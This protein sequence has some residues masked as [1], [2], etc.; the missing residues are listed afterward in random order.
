MGGVTMAKKRNLVSSPA[1]ARLEPGPARLQAGT[2]SPGPSM[3]AAVP[4][5][6][7]RLLG[8][9]YHS[10]PWNMARVRLLKDNPPCYKCGEPATD[11][12]LAELP[13][14]GCRPGIHP[15]NLRTV[16]GSCRRC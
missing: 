2:S 14:I 10:F 15:A 11:I 12:E 9:L 6:D 8:M 4:R 5:V 13:P 7:P 3:P 1:T 16:C